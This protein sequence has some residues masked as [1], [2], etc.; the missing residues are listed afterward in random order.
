MK[1]EGDFFMFEE[2]EWSCLFYKLLGSA[3]G[4]SSLSNCWPHWVSESYCW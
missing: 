3:A 2:T 1:K 4:S